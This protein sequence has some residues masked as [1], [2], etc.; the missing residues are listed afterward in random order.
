MR[1]LLMGN[2]NVGKSVVFSRMTGARVITSNY[3]GTTVEYTRGYMRI[4]GQR[5]EIADVPGTYSLEPT[6]KAEE[7]ACRMLEEAS[8][9]VIVI[10][11]VDATN[12][13]RSLNLT[14]QLLKRRV[15]MVLVL[16]LWDEAGHIGVHIDAEKLEQILGVPCVPTVAVTG[17]GI[18]KLVERLSEARESDY[19]YGEDEKWHEIG[20]IVGKVQRITHR[21]HTPGEMLA[22][23]SVKPFPGALIAIGILLLA[24]EVIRTI[25]EGLIGRVGEP[26][27]EG[28]WAPVMLRLSSLLGGTGF[29]HDLL[30]GRL[31][32]GEID[33]GQ[34]FGLLTT[35]LFVP[36]A[37]VL[38]YVFAFYLVLSFLED[39]GYLPR[40]AILLDS[41]MHRVGLHGMAVVPMLLGLGCNVPG[42]LSTRI[43]ESR[44]E[45]F[46]AGTLMAIC[47]PC[48]AQ[49]SMIVGLAGKHGARSLLPIFGTLFVVWILLGRL[50]E[51]F[52]RGE[53]PEILMDVPPYRIPHLG[54]FL[55]KMWM[56][57]F[58]FLREAIP[59]VLLGVLL[60][61]VLYSL[62]VIQ[63]I[64]EV[65]AVVITGILGLPKEAVGGLVV[66]F[67]R[68]DVA[69]GMLAPLHLSVKQLIVACVV[70]TMYFP[71]VATFAVMIKELGILDMLKA[72][73]IMVISALVVGGFLNLIL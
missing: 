11:I 16:N 50:L 31:V 27:F 29:V 42:A 66:G 60:V 68:K 52:I 36:F 20:E 3:P 2:P 48:M 39:S 40:L 45:R 18:K 32:D 15:P 4:A 69:V 51:R 61:N 19:E 34:S 54:G 63:F 59:W 5:V 12:L 13:E 70:L 30:V 10:N 24:F 43:M 73:A 41:I 58:W 72:A 49:V 7:I 56:R 33:F 37:A 44:K 6:C 22:D 62:G 1:I 46:I 17:E 67:L 71:C 21:H 28:L 55:K 9:N 26:V 25:G 53:S 35:G 47:V 8:D 14:L 23:A 64:G 38:P 57:I 65:A